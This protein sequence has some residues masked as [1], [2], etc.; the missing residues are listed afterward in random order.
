M[1]L[2]TLKDLLVVLSF[3]ACFFREV[4]NPLAHIIIPSFDDPTAYLD[5]NRDY[6]G[7]SPVLLK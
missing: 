3:F 2:R 4:G 6:A 1:E 7:S 5:V